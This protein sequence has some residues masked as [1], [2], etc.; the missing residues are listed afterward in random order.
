MENV[1]TAE[2]QAGFTAKPLVKYNDLY[3][4]LVACII[5]SHIIVAYGE[6]LSTFEIILTAAYYP[7]FIG[8]F[9]IA[10]ILMSALRKVCTALDKRFDW[11]E[12]P[13]VRAGLQFFFGLVVPG[14]FAF[15]LATLYFRIRGVNIFRTSYL[16]YDF[17]F[18]LMQVLIINIYYVAWYFYSRWS[19]AEQLIGSLGIGLSKT[20]PNTQKETFQVSK[21][22][23][24]TVLATSEIAYCYREGESNF[25][26]TMAGED[27]F[28]TQSLD[29]VQQ[30][31]PEQTFFRANRQLVLQRAACKGYELLSYG[32]LKA[33]VEPD[34]PAE[35]VI[36]QKRA[37]AFKRW[38]E[39]A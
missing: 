33:Q 36:S 13:T 38:L 18:I 22:A 23:R 24:N 26:R 7:A 5:A 37:L 21:G 1:I 16:R 15:M 19:Q 31:L 39:A 9:I 3:L 35:V 2:A 4:R 25:V 8:S 14:I 28:I 10:F 32:K 27:F 11:K 12:Q 30:Q 20:A 17:Q 6:P 34:C 29:E